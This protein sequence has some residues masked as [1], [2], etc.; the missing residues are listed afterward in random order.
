MI[1]VAIVAILSTLAIVGYRRLIMSSHTSEATHMV[2][3]IRVA[4]E[5]YHA[6]TGSY[7]WISTSLDA[8]MC[9]A[10]SAQPT[11]VPWDPACDGGK[12]LWSTLPVHSDG[13][14]LFYSAT[15]AG[16]SSVKPTMPTGMAVTPAM[17]LITSDWF[18]ISA[19]A[20]NDNNGTWCTVVGTSWTN[21]IYVD[22]DG[23]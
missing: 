18:T 4:Q 2:Q 7:S 11:K 20:D 15:V 13:P 12:A 3:G 23:E 8:T 1:V 9:P 10:H 6:E 5:T 21:D 16:A 19:K 17:T 22:R 14:V